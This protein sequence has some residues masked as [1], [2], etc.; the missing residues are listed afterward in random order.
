VANH[1]QDLIA[2]GELKPDDRLPP[3]SEL[4][5]QFGVSRTV[6]REATRSL[7]H[8]GLL[9]SEPRRGT[10]V[11]AMPAQVFSKSV[12]LFVKSTEISFTDLL[13]VRETLEIKIAQLA[14]ERATSD[15]LEQMRRAM[16][17]MDRHIGSV[18]PFLKADLEFHLALALAAHNE[19]LFALINSLTDEVTYTQYATAQPHGGF[20]AAQQCHRQIYE[21][22]VCGD[23]EGAG[24]AMSHHL[25]TVRRHLKTD[26]GV[27]KES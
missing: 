8:S 12:D 2:G 18:E 11:T 24:Q 13:E 7:I 23:K 4:C 22:L 20:L 21:Q 27:A 9:S 5:E 25:E 6:I 14:A 17:T 16:E 1:I 26:G 10:F 3:E 19:L 15:D